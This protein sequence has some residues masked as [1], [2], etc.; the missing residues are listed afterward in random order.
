MLA[1]YLDGDTLH[2]DTQAEAF[3]PISFGSPVGDANGA[4]DAGIGFEFVC[5]ESLRTHLLGCAEC[6]QQLQRARRLDAA[7]AAGAGRAFAEQHTMVALEQRW[8]ANVG[9]AA[10][11]VGA[12]GTAARGEGRPDAGTRQVTAPRWHSSAPWR[13]LVLPSAVVTLAATLF[14]WLL[15]ASSHHLQTR[16]PGQ[17]A[18]P[19][20]SPLAPTPMAPDRAAPAL[21]ETVTPMPGLPEAG[22]VEIHIAQDAARRANSAAAAKGERDVDQRLPSLGELRRR[23]DDGAAEPEQCMMAARQLLQAC[24]SPA[25]AGDAAGE[26]LVDALAGFGDRTAKSRLLHH[27]LLDL[28][29]GEPRF[30]AHVQRRLLRLETRRPVADKNGREATIGL[31]ELGALT[32]AAR[33]GLRTL[34]TAILRVLRRQP[35]LADPLAAAL[36]SGARE[37]GAARL[38]L[39]AWQEMV[40]RGDLGA[41]EFR[42][43]A[44]FAGQPA[45]IFD[46]LI[47]EVR[48]SGSA[49][50]RVHCLLALGFCPTATAVPVLLE[51]MQKA[52][53]LEAHAAAFALSQQPRKLLLPLLER[54]TRND[55]AFLLRAALARAALPETAQWTAELSLRATERS[56]L[57]HGPF[58]DFPSVANWFRERPVATGD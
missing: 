34:D 17:P 9:M 14:G 20:G 4:D 56:Q 38:L 39:D 5:G 33:L 12:A 22:P 25:T 50:R 47:T 40:A 11:P 37:A 58:G 6:Q 28:A 15:V 45:A 32:V 36:R 7:L 2:A 41:D 23:C 43:Q 26:V 53:H 27:D 51:R 30:V 35:D 16:A 46:D 57:C 42:A 8:F 3:G 49:P 24:R 54:A 1:I 31:P 13:S 29:R 10:N 48:T 44:W 55:D 52:P 21:P 18:V 19:A